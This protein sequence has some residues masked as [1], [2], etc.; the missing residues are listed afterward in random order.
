[1]E[2][3]QVNISTGSEQ[4][5]YRLRRRGENCNRRPVMKRTRIASPKRISLTKYITVSVI[6]SLIV[7]LVIAVFS[8]DTRSELVFWLIW[9]TGAGVV[10]AII[11]FALM[12]KLKGRSKH[13]R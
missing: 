12:R 11:E 3:R 4:N 10:F 1:M 9:V 7:G 13:R 6:V 8:P 5:S 2:L